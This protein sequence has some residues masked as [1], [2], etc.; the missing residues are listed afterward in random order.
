MQ[1]ITNTLLSLLTALTL[2][3]AK[4]ENL[5]AQIE[6]GHSMGYVINGVE[7][8]GEAAFAGVGLGV[9]YNKI[10]F[11][12]GSTAL[13]GDAGSD[14]KFG[15]GKG[16]ALF[17]GLTAQV[18]LDTYRH[19]LATSSTETALS[20]ALKNKFITPYIKG[21]YDFDLNEQGYTVGLTKDFTIFTVQIAPAVEFAKFESYET[22]SVK[23]G[24]AKDI[25]K[26]IQLFSDVGYY[27]ANGAPSYSTRDIDGKFLTTAGVRWVF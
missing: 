4:A 3:T 11:S 18:S 23:V 2:T 1:K 8:A 6:A 21:S 12:L 13:L 14:W 24:G 10:D 7:R 20:L 17:D 19:Q 5:T 25:F 15:V 9:T 22:F 27:D 26:H 16:F